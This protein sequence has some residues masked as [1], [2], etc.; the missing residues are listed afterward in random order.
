MVVR[1][2]KAILR[3]EEAAFDAA[4][5]VFMQ[6]LRKRSRLDARG[7]SSLLYTIATNTCLNILRAQRRR[8]GQHAELH[9]ELLRDHESAEETVLAGHFLE[10]LFAVEDDTTRLIAMYH[11]LDGFTLEETAA[12]VGMSVSGIR[13]R[14]RK[15]RSTSLALREE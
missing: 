12:L 11:Y 4:Q 3:N 15:L 6:L 10:R 8:G 7:P 13:K 14:L 2:C 1:R 5:D 9:E